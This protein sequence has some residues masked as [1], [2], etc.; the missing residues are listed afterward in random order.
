M[1]GVNTPFL[2]RWPGV[3]PAGRV[4][5]LT[6]LAGVDVLP[7]VLAAAGIEVPDTYQPDGE[8]M[9]P[10]LQGEPQQRAR[11]L[12][13][14]WPGGHSGDDWP[15][16][17][18]REGP[19]MLLLDES[20]DRAELYNVVTD[21]GQSQNLA[22][23]EPERVVRMKAAIE[24]WFQTLPKSVNPHLQ[25]KEASGGKQSSRP[26]SPDRARAF[27]R[28]DT[29][30]DGLLSLEEYTAGLTNRTN[31]RQ[32]FE[33]FDADSDGTLTRIEFVGDEP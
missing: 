27:G 5:R 2:V 1:G 22:S 20:R 19:W 4:D 9:L 10:A 28:W 32:R 17:A 33:N 7:T 11:S 29:N 31:A 14:W 26:V 30:G 16:F 21:R 3:V 23:T 18:M 6:A 25:S 8:N 15:A 12:F 13:W 24:E